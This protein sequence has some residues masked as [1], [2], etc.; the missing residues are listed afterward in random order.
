VARRL[1]RGEAH[2]GRLAQAD[3]LVALELG[4]A[5]D[6]GAVDERRAGARVEVAQ[7]DAPP[8]Q[9][10]EA[11][12]QR[13]DP[14]TAQDDRASRSAAEGHGLVADLDRVPP[15]QP[16]RHLDPHAGPLPQSETPGNGS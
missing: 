12:V 15:A 13:L 2:D 11:R 16:R 8:G 1:L 7:L 14:R 4:A 5:V 6:A 10:D 3:L 9:R